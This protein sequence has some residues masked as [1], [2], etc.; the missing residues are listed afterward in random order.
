MITIAVMIFDGLLAIDDKS[1][2]AL[3]ALAVLM[4]THNDFQTFKV[5]FL[6]IDTAPDL[7][8]CPVGRPSHK[9]AVD[10]VVGLTGS[11]GAR[12]EICACQLEWRRDNKL[13]RLR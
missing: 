1:V 10:R 7:W 8:A 2:A 5:R 11:V 12:V 9:R 4:N 3:R 13:S 6:L